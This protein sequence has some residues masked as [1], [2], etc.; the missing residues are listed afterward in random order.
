M[1]AGDES[2]ALRSVAGRDQIAR[3]KRGL[4]VRPTRK[5]GVKSVRSS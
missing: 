4:V 2:S 3:P 1:L 5:L